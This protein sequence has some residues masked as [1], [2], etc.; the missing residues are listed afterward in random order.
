MIKRYKITL[1]EVIDDNGNYRKKLLESDDSPRVLTIVLISICSAFFCLSETVF[2]HFNANYFQLIPLK[3]TANKTTEFVLVSAL[4]YTI[5]RG[6][7]ALIALIIKPQLMVI[8]H[9]IAVI[10]GIIVLFFGQNFFYTLLIGN[11]ITS[12]GF[13]CI[14]PA[15]YAFVNQVLDLNNKICG[16]IMFWADF[17]NLFIPYFLGIFI[18]KYPNLFVISIATS[19]SL[20][21]I[22]FIMILFIIICFYNTFDK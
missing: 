18:E 22:I 3:L 5:G 1:Q 19:A 14:G 8:N 21:F 20:S 10:I 6:L 15:M 9:L 4:T 2:F 17:P 7:N 12:I 13:S 11:I 16:I